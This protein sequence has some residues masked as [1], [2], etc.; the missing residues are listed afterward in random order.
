MTSFSPRANVNE[1]PGNVDERSVDFLDAVDAVRRHNQTKIS[2][3]GE[4]AA[5]LPSQAIVSI[6]FSPAASRA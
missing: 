1:I 5:V 4:A 6:S 2:H 3:F